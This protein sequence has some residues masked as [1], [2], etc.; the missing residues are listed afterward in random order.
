MQRQ[1]RYVEPSQLTECPAVRFI[2]QGGVA[3]F[4]R[5]IGDDYELGTIHVLDTDNQVWHLN[6]NYEY[7]EG[8]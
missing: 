6:D 7:Q 8:Q 1:P 5:V 2:D 4:G 3:R